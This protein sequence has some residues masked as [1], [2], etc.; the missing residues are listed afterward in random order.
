MNLPTLSKKNLVSVKIPNLPLLMSVYINIASA[1]W[2]ASCTMP[3]S[4]THYLAAKIAFC[5]QFGK[6]RL[7]IGFF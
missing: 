7:F 3:F 5:L 1:A 4:N 2:R 6:Y